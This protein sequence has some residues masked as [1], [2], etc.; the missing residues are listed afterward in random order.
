MTS[1]ADLFALQAIDLKRDARRALIADIESRL[2]ETEELTAA[3]ELVATCESEVERLRREQRDLE[4]RTEDLDA[5][6]QPVE[7][8]LYG[9]SIRNPKELTDLQKELDLLKRRR[10]DL[11][12]EGLALIDAL[13]AA[14]S[15]LERARAGMRAVQ[16][17]W[18]ADQE[19]L[20]DGKARAQREAAQL[21]SER[22][23]RTKG[24]DAA[25]LGL[26][27]KLRGARQGRGV[28]RVERGSC[29]GC[30]LGLPT[31]LVQRLRAG[32]QLVQCPSCERILVAG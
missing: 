24:M 1:A 9:G 32:G 2:G 8:R 18:Q 5:R 12:D 25:A 19:E 31:H 6:I 15:A 20:A 27:E 14:T 30:R 23:L 21:N 16:A 26:Y 28:A 17:A 22:E 7:T 4:A 3:R 13:E 11:D 10:G 29:Q